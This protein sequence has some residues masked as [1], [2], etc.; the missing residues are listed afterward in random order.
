MKK[1]KATALSPGL[2]AI[3]GNAE[4]A[5]DMPPRALAIVNEDESG[6]SVPLNFKVPPG[7]RRAFRTYA[8][9]HDLKM[10]ALLARCFE[11]YRKQ[12][13]D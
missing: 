1:E 7:F 4:P 10:N 9:S 3:K 11:A 5:P 2:V 13:G 12:Q 6:D 8:A